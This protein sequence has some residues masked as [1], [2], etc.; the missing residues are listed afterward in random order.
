VR[1]AATNRQSLPLIPIEGA[2]RQDAVVD[3][4]RRD[5]RWDDDADDQQYR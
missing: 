2:G 3:W 4:Q 1:Q 5:E